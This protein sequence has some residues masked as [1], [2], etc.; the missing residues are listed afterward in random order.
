MNVKYYMHV[1]HGLGAAS[2]VAD[3]PDS[4]TRISIVLPE[5]QRFYGREAK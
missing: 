1:L 5:L 4:V 2:R 3:Q